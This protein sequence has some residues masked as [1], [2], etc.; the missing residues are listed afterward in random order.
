MKAFEETVDLEIKRLLQQKNYPCIA[1]LQSYHRKDYWLKS[2]ENFGGCYQRPDLREDLLSYLS[3]YETSQS[4]FFTFWAVFNDVDNLDEDQ[5][6]LSMWRELSSLTSTATHGS[7]TNPRFSSDPLSKN[8]C[9]TIGGHAFFVVGLHPASSRLSRRFPWP[10][11][12]FNTF[13]QFE[14]LKAKEQYYPMIETNRLRDEKFQ[15]STNPMVALY[16]D[17]WESIQFSGK[18]NE[19]SWLC[20]FRLREV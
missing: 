2:Y 17:L 18:K 3:E 1:A 8:F 19:S 20:P 7:D 10:A 12:V 5:F 9:F 14:T 15:G 4:P 13:E 16:A 11:L 6:E